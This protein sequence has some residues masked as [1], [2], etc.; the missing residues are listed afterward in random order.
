MLSTI[1]WNSEN[2][3]R[4]LMPII[5]GYSTSSLC[6]NKNNRRSAGGNVVFRPP[7]YVF[8]IVW[9]ILYIMLGLSWV[10][11]M[12]SNNR[13]KNP[14]FVELCYISISILLASWI[15]VYGCRNRK[16]LGI[17]VIVLA[18]GSIIVTMNV[19]GVNSRLLLT[20]LLTW[21]FLALFMNVAEVQN[22]RRR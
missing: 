20:P 11:S 8:G 18:L 4:L 12:K 9:P 1:Y 7:A 17:Y 14:V 6:W 15:A 16:I 22:V 21:L 13:A 3:I 2:V 19:V 10:L 5:L